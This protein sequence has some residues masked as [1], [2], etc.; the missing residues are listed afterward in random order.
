MVQSNLFFT[1][2]VRSASQANTDVTAQRNSIDALEAT[3]R[4]LMVKP[5]MLNT[6]SDGYFPRFPN[7]T[8]TSICERVG[9]VF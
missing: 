7:M 5:D 3:I 1:F 9:E 4:K 2:A 6:R 8:N